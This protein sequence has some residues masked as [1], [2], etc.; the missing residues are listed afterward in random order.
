MDEPP[1]KIGKKDGCGGQ[2]NVKRVGEIVDDA[3]V[4]TGGMLGMSGSSAGN[5][6]HRDCDRLLDHFFFL[7]S[8]GIELPRAGAQAYAARV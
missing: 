8:G 7:F 6:H 3:E 1:G 2:R 5:E 4:A